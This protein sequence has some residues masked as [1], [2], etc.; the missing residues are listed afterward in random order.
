MWLLYIYCY[1]IEHHWNRLYDFMGLWSKV[2]EWMGDGYLKSA[3]ILNQPQFWSIQPIFPK[4]SDWPQMSAIYSEMAHII[5]VNLENPSWVGAF[6]DK[7][8]LLE[9]RANTIWAWSV[10]HPFPPNS[11]NAQKKTFFSLSMSSLR[12]N[13]LQSYCYMWQNLY[14][15]IL[16]IVYIYIIILYIVYIYINLLFLK[17]HKK[18]RIIPPTPLML[19]TE[20]GF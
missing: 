4:D 9:K 17:N 10:R 3:E 5:W 18:N 13:H 14:F 1:V 15:F 19:E 7:N 16:Y 2:S 20:W 6:I 12:Q 8:A 11:G